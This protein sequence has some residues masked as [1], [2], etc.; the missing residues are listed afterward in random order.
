[1]VT[2]CSLVA[3]VAFSAI[4]GVSGEKVI[5]GAVAKPHSRP[6]M[7]YLIINRSDHHTSCG[8][9]LIREDFVLTA[10]HC[11]GNK[12]TALLGAQNVLQN[13]ET[14]QIIGVEKSFP[15]PLYN[16]GTYD[17]MLLKLKKKA[18]LGVAVGLIPVPWRRVPPGTVCS[19]AGWGAVDREGRNASPELQEVNV[20]VLSDKQ[21]RK[22]WGDQYDE[23]KICGG[24]P[25][26]GVCK[27]DS[28]G[29]LVCEEKAYGIVS[30]GG[31]LCEEMPTI[32]TKI[33]VYEPWINETLAQ[34]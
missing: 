33:S 30:R 8:G 23:T 5:G 2:L 14:Q 26:H 4:Q 16:N 7:V 22:R 18:R 11:D 17:I 31:E 25:D 24:M 6:Y 9:F 13:E 12:L 15:H 27:G 10:A 28:G 34:N 1:M 32:Y 19:V 3:L 29:P 21:C 20:T